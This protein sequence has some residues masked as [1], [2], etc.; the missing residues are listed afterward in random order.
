ML[1]PLAVVSTLVSRFSPLTKIFTGYAAFAMLVGIVTTFSRGGWVATGLSLAVLALWL[2]QQRGYRLQVAIISAALLALGTFVAFKAKL[3]PNRFEQIYLSAQRDNTRFPIW[4]VAANMWH[5]HLWWG[6]GPGHFDHR[7]PQYRPEDWRLQ[8]RPDRVHNDYLNTLADWG[9][10]GGLLAGGM[11]GVFLWQVARSWRYV[12]RAQNDLKT[13]RSNKGAIV[14][15][16]AVGLMAILFHSAIDFNFQIPA[17]AI[18]AMTLMALVAGHFRFASERYWHTVRWPLRIPVTLLLT[19]AIL[20]LGWQSSRAKRETGFLAAAS[21]APSASRQQID[22]LKA[23]WAVEGKNAETAYRIGEAYRL[24]SFALAPGYADLAKEALRWFNAASQLN[25]FDPLPLLKAGM[26]QDW[27]DK[28]EEA[29]AL[30]ER[31]RVLDPN[32]YYTRALLGWHFFQVEEYEKAREWLQASL[33]IRG[34]DNPIATSYLR[35]TEEKL[36]ERATRW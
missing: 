17:N 20:Y 5:E 2:F 9:M 12:Q 31:A 8:A 27:L 16:G 15:G 34:V 7:Y 19:V 22:L 33:K 24:Q 18:L 30:F 21:V 23:A 13:R 32:G 26:A 1:L 35:L 6:V 36:A 10:V 3:S 28:P 25:P 4:G 14:M 11:F 29:G